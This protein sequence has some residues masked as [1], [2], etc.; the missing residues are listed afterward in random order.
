MARLATILTALARALARD[1]KS[2]WSLAGNNFFITI[3]L[4]MSMLKMQDAGGFLLVIIGL[5]VLFPLSTDPLRKIPASRLTLWPLDSRERWG[6]RAL[7]PWIN[8]MTWLLAAL[9][10]WTAQGKVSMGL[11]AIAAV[12]VLS[13]FALS[14]MPFRI[15]RAL[16]RHIPGFPGSLNQLIRKNLR[17]ML[18]TLDLY[19]GLILG[20]GTGLYQLFHGPLPPEGLMVVTVLVVIA[21]SSSAQCLFGLDGKGGLTRY[22]ILPLRGWQILAAKDAAFLLIGAALTL[23]VAPLAGIG[24]ALAA[25]AIGHRHSVIASAP[26][27]RW[28]FS[29][30]GTFWPEGLMQVVAIALAAS[31]IRLTSVWFLI[32]CVLACIGSAWWYGRFIDNGFAPA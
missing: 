7:S 24:A 30:G 1:Q 21:L 22:R 23:P 16:W 28:R 6:L 9:G 11:L 17:Q 19:C 14:S 5:V 26:Q 4:M 18:S 10:V 2:I 13:S 15:D 12:L 31:S 8:P 29:A 32:P 3:V 27:A 20:G 25:L